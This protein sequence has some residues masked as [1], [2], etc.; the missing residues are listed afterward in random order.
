MVEVFFFGLLLQVVNID[1]IMFTMCAQFVF[2]TLI[3]QY[4][5]R[6]LFDPVFV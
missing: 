3:V 4:Y 5:K 2:E 1:K 6:T